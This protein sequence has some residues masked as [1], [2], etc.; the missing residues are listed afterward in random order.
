MRNRHFFQ[1]LSNKQGLIID[2]R[3]TQVSQKNEFVISQLN[4]SLRL[5]VKMQSSSNEIKLK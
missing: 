5:Q 1:V 3:V 2:N 4:E